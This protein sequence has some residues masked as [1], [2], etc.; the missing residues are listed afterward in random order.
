ML[1]SYR[2]FAAVHPAARGNRARCETAAG[3]LYSV[4]SLCAET[5]RKP[6]RDRTGSSSGRYRSIRSRIG[7]S[8]RKT[9]WHA[10]EQRV[11]A[12]AGGINCLVKITQMDNHEQKPTQNQRLSPSLLV[13]DCWFLS[14]ELAQNRH[15]AWRYAKR[16]PIGKWANQLLLTLPS[17]SSFFPATGMNR[18]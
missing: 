12:S 6:N 10:F 15:S 13:H 3:L 11:E 9:H 17:S 14:I 4:A 2:A 1:R 18:D 7:R 5:E 8:D 16:P